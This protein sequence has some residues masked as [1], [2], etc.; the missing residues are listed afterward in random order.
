MPQGIVA[1]GLMHAGGFQAGDSCLR[2]NSM[3]IRVAQLRFLV[4]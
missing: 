3:Q 1:L 2:C 4:S